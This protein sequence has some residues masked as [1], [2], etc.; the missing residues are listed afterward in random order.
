MVNLKN[1]AMSKKKWNPWTDREINILIS[2][3]KILKTTEIAKLLPERSLASIYR[4]ANDIMLRAYNSEEYY[5]KILQENKGKSISTI[6]KNYGINWY[7]VRYH[8]KKFKSYER[9]R[10]QF[11]GSMC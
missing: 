2:N 3:Y 10:T 6:S 1:V 7:T 4:N 11:A 5:Q 8:L 9:E